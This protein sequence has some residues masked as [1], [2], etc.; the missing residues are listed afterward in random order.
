MLRE[1]GG[2]RHR[3]GLAPGQRR[4]RARS[5]GR[6][7]DSRAQLDAVAPLLGSMPRDS[8]WLP[9]LA[10]VAETLAL[11]G[12]HPVARWVYDAL[13]PYAQLFA[14]EGI[15]AAVRG[16]VSRH[17]GLL[18]TALGDRAAAAAHF[19]A[20]G[21]AA[22]A[23]GADPGGHADR[24]GGRTGRA[25][26]GQAARDAGE[27]APGAV[28][29]RDGEVWTLGYQGREVR[30]R[31]SKGLRDLAV[32]LAR[33]GSAVAALDLAAADADGRS[34]AT[35]PAGLHQPADTG[36]VLD[37]QAREAYKRRLAELEEEA[38]EA[39]AFADAERSARVAAERDALVAALAE[40]YGLG[41][42]PR[43]GRLARRAGPHRGDRPH[44]GRDPPDRRG[45]SPARQAPVAF[46]ADRDVLLLRAGAAGPLV[47]VRPGLTS[48]ARF[49]RPLGKAPRRKEPA[50]PR[51]SKADAPVALDEPPIEGRY[52]QLD[53]YTVGVRDPQGRH[54][55]GAA[56]PRPARRPLPVPALGRRAHRPDHLQVHRPRRGLQGR[57]TP[58][59]A[60]PGTC[61]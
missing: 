30:L 26:R 55:P 27:P 58:T 35:E 7:G 22:R 52:V 10:Q 28:F 38:S 24:R 20:A 56:V 17:L 50:M 43:R 33:P 5:A 32:L 11:I 61:R 41:G 3:G 6:P 13:A 31:D 36:E 46:G 47:A 12:P 51:T 19:A 18:A 1:L 45:P 25:P 16:P 48:C 60:R 44:Q 49:S 4:A 15:C 59:T 9:A 21:Q 53:E 40:A 57:V 14:V 23:I 39:D 2:C 29:R 42:R 37:H 34:R 54:G 8:E